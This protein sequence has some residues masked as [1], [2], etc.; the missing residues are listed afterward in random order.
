VRSN[1]HDEKNVGA[2]YDDGI[3]G[4]F[5]EPHEVREV[6]TASHKTL[7][8]RSRRRARS[9]AGRVS[10]RQKHQV[11]TVSSYRSDF[12]CVVNLALK[13]TRPRSKVANNG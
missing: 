9:T 3:E 13:R 5:E 6:H 4:S 1:T 7:L 12:L 2:E 11:S 10:S 8:E